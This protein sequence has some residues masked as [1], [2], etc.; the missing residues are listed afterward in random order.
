[1]ISNKLFANCQ[2]KNKPFESSFFHAVGTQ[3]LK[4]KVVFI[5][6]ILQRRLFTERTP[7]IFKISNLKDIGQ[8]CLTR[9][10][11]P[12]VRESICDS[13]EQIIFNFTNK[14]SRILFAKSQSFHIRF[15][16]VFQFTFSILW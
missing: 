11:C 8:I 3:Q 1:M 9:T 16:F 10:F 5:V 4:S 15:L 6:P 2:F 13:Q 14:M 7:T 12:E